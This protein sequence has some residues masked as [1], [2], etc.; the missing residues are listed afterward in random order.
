M[1]TQLSIYNK[2]LV[3]YLGER[4]LASLTERQKSRRVLDTI[5]D[6]GLVGYCLEVG[7]WTDGTRTVRLDYDTNI[8]PDFGFQRVFAVPDDYEC[9]LSICL[10][11]FFRN[12]LDSTSF[13]HEA[14]YFFSNLDTIY[15][16]YVSSDPLYGGG[17]STWP[18]TLADF[19]AAEAAA[20]GALAITKSQSR[21]DAARDNADR[22]KSIA[23]SIDAKRKPLQ[24]PP[25]GR[26]VGARMQ[27][28]TSYEKGGTW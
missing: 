8:Q 16:R 4:K 28:R 6:G 26:L 9:T 14:G 11:E 27:G 17:M 7:N 15:L 22:M 19:V 5:W 21:A 2:A 25:V 13:V 18:A 10:D 3:E 1:A 20:R 12:P 24:Q 23:T